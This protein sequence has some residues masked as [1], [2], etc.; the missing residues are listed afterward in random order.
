MCQEE[1]A[2]TKLPRRRPDLLPCA[3]NP[4]L[5]GE[6]MT[7]GL[8]EAQR[9]AEEAASNPLTSFVDSLMNRVGARATARAAF[10]EAV[11]RDGVTVIP[12]ARVRWMFGGGAGSGANEDGDESDQGQGAGGGGAV[13]AAP[14]GYIEIRDGQA[15]FHRIDDPVSLWPLIVASAVSAWVVLRGLKALIR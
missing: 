13:S 5:G 1:I 6:E 8:D 3:L 4:F 15:V 9:E 10:G 2:D 7:S 11:E 14:L 12:V